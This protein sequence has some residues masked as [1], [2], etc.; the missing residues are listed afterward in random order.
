[1]SSFKYSKRCSGFPRASVI[2][3]KRSNSC[4]VCIDR[5]GS[6]FGSYRCCVSCP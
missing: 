3:C 1:V 4:G 5:I 6:C 2:L